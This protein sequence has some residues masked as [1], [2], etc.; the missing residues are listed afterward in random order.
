MYNGPHAFHDLTHSRARGENLLLEQA[1]T[2]CPA[3][4][5]DEP[6]VK[7]FERGE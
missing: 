6:A 2:Y 5:N 3:E 4:C 1:K 7:R